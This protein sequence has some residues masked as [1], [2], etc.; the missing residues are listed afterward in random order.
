M[1]QALKDVLDVILDDLVTQLTTE[2]ATYLGNNERYWQGKATHTTPPADGVSTI[3]N[4]GAKPTDQAEA[5]DDMTGLTIP[6][7][8]PVCLEVHTYDAPAGKGYVVIGTAIESGV[9]YN[10]AINV[11]PLT[12]RSHDWEVV[13]IGI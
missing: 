3:C 11:G 1:T 6:T 13:S 7:T 9:T 8:L 4:L 5:W 12:A 10:K 2:Q